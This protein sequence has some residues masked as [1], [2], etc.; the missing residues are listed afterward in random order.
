MIKQ[1]ISVF[2]QSTYSSFFDWK[3]SSAQREVMR[4]SFILP[5]VYSLIGG[6]SILYAMTGPFTLIINFNAKLEDRSFAS[7]KSSLQIVFDN[8]QSTITKSHDA[9]NNTTV[10]CALS[11]WPDQFQIEL[12]K[13]TLKEKL[14]AKG[15]AADCCNISVIIPPA[16]ET[17]KIPSKL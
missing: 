2:F 9:K 4:K 6:F 12:L 11:Y 5:F 3:N 7:L 14:A 10:F 8:Q 1:T 17:H 16:T 15:I 13:A